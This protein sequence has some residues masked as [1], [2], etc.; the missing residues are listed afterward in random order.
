VFV[1]K[2]LSSK[3]VDNG[4]DVNFTSG[5]ESF[6]FKFR[7]LVL[8]SLQKLY[9]FLVVKLCE[10]LQARVASFD[11][12]VNENTLNVEHIIANFICAIDQRRIYA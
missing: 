1:V 5:V 6:E 4:W 2:C 3:C 11:G 10:Y 7:Y 12:F 8:I 9:I